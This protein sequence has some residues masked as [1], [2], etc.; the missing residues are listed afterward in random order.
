MFLIIQFSVKNDMSDTL[1]NL[2]TKLNSQ[3]QIQTGSYETVYKKALEHQNV[4][5]TY[6][7]HPA[8]LPERPHYDQFKFRITVGSVP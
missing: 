2:I 8:Y 3:L 4:P 1:G 7:G 5:F 6:T